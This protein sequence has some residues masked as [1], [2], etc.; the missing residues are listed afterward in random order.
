MHSVRTWL[1]KWWAISRALDA[2]SAPLDT[3]MTLLDTPRSVSRMYPS[4]M[5]P[6]HCLDP[7][8]LLGLSPAL[9]DT[10]SDTLEACHQQRRSLIGRVWSPT[11]PLLIAGE[12]AALLLT[13]A[14]LYSH[15][16]PAHRACVERRGMDSLQS[17]NVTRELCF[18]GKTTLL[19]NMRS[20]RRGA[21]YVDQGLLY[22]PVG[23]HRG[24]GVLLPPHPGADCLQRAVR[25]APSR[26]IKSVLR[27]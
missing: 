4:S 17:A 20:G 5:A 13:T 21:T 8:K 12:S 6:I 2:I 25:A 14:Q 23:W 15:Q 10:M 11:E 27:R 9:C 19:P 24:A 16:Q 3:V 1:S 26:V 22:L 18:R 7:T